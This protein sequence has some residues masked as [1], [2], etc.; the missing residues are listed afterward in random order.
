MTPRPLAFNAASR[1]SENDRL[2]PLYLPSAFAFA[3]P[4]RWR[5]NINSRSNSAT[6]PRTLKINLSRLADTRDTREIT[7]LNCQLRSRQSRGG[8]KLT[9][10]ATTFHPP[11]P[12]E[13]FRRVGVVIGRAPSPS[14]KPLDARRLQR[15][16]PLGPFS[17][18]LKRES[19]PLTL[20][21]FDG[22]HERAYCRHIAGHGPGRQRRLAP[23]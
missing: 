15:C 19:A 23:A 6:E 21:A 20:S 2:R 3:I 8:P 5:S 22:Q 10:I 13:P 12:L 16:R 17:F 7:G 1:S 14:P 4:T 9:A 18:W 11:G